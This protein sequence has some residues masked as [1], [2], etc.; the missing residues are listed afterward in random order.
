[1]D[2]SLQ[3]IVFQHSSFPD[4]IACFDCQHGQDIIFF[5]PSSLDWLWGM[6]SPCF[7]APAAFSPDGNLPEC[8]AGSTVSILLI[9]T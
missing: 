4:G 9:P 6:C 7:L 1:M 2:T 8:D 5:S 3:A